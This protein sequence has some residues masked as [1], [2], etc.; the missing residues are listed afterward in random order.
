MLCHDSSQAV[1]DLSSIVLHHVPTPWSK[2]TVH[3]PCLMKFH[4]IKPAGLLSLIAAKNDAVP[5]PSTSPDPLN[6]ADLLPKGLPV[7]AL[8]SDL[9]VSQVPK[10]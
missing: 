10:R 3:H 1:G 7:L 6:I 2:P 5:T 9:Y 4:V 8:S